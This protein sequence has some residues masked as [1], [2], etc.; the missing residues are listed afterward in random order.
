MR[1]SDWSSDVCSSDLIDETLPEA[2]A[3]LDARIGESRGVV[4]GAKPELLALV[5][6]AESTH[7]AI[8]AIAQVIQGQRTT[9]DQLSAKLIETLDAGRTKADSPGKMF[10]ETIGRTHD[11]DEES[12]PKLVEALIPGRDTPTA[13]AGRGRETRA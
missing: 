4:S 13:N 11:F 3:R 9:V 10:D 6:A 7:D 1:I 2:L 5:T 12:D 8:E